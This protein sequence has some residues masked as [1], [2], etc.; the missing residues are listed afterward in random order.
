MNHC[1]SFTDF[2][3]KFTIKH[4]DKLINSYH[5]D[6]FSIRN[7]LWYSNYIGIE[8]DKQRLFSI[9]FMRQ[10]PQYLLQEGAIE[11]N[12]STNRLCVYTCNNNPINIAC[13]E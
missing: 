6:S 7:I 9:I 11:T 13:I 10:L 12:F 2:P 1:I 4:P 3:E 8:S 5:F